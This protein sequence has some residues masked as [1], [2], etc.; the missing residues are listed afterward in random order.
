MIQIQ[1][2]SKKQAMLADILWSIGP[3]EKVNRFINSLPEADKIDALI[4]KD[5]LLA[6]VFDEVERTTEAKKILDTIM[7]D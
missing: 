1:G 3:L 6:A 4:V 2:F 5:M 7:R